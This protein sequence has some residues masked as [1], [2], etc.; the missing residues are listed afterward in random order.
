MGKTLEILK[1]PYQVLSP[2]SPS[3][4]NLKTFTDFG[5]SILLN[6]RISKTVSAEIAASCKKHTQKNDSQGIKLY[7]D[8]FSHTA[9]S[10][11][12]GSH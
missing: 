3:L 4:E 2:N 8:L 11:E 5:E 6:S 1:A 10:S 7:R 12:V 9:T